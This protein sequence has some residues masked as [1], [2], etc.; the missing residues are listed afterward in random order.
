[1]KQKVTIV[2]PAY[3]AEKTLER[4]LNDIPPGSY[5]EIILVD[6]FSKDGTVELSKK[7]GLTDETD[8]VKIERDLM[9]IIPKKE[10]F[11]FTYRLIDY[12]RKYCVARPHD[13]KKCSLSKYESN[14]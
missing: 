8:P 3:N 12:G 6:D 1:M 2:M 7:L 9:A 11:L 13:S 5:D 4:T 10:W 14:I